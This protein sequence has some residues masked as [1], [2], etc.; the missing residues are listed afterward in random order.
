MLSWG[1]IGVLFA[2][3]FGVSVIF[4][5]FGQGGG[6]IYVPMLLA[7]GLPLYKAAA[8]SQVLIIAAT[9]SAML[10][11]QKA[12]MIDWWL[13]LIVEPPTNLGAFLGGYFSPYFPPM[14][15]K[16]V[17]AGI[18]LIGAYFMIK[19]IQEAEKT[20]PVVK[21]HWFCLHRKIGEF[22]Y[23]LNLLV[24]IPIMILAG[25]IAGMLGVGGGLFKV[26]ALVL[27]GGVPMKIAVGSSSLMI[28][29]T[30]LTGLI[31][32]ALVGH[33]DPRLAL[34]LGGA[35]FSGAQVGARLGVKIDKKKHKKYFGYLLIFIACWMVY[36][37]FKRG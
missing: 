10:V 34:V 4:M 11:F 20:Y 1:Q 31:G 14:F 27:L 3:F 2:V 29:I 32:H 17:F 37:A 16:L 36:M 19:P 6:A 22:E 13:A 7:F 12:K 18:L 21:R 25:F 28:G 30:A 9:I 35:V 24:I 26:P 5:M 15:S 8:I 23:H 33:F